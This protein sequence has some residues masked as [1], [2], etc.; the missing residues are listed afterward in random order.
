[1]KTTEDARRNGQERNKR[2][3]KIKTEVQETDINGKHQTNKKNITKKAT[4]TT[5]QHKKIDE[6]EHVHKK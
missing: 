2:R 1:M 5:Q 6:K 4:Q 3:R